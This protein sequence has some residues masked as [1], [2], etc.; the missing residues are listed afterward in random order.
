MDV[1]RYLFIDLFWGNFC[2]KNSFSHG[3]FFSLLPFIEYLYILDIK[4]L[5]YKIL[6]FRYLSCI[7]GADVFVLIINTALFGIVRSVYC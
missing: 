6:K 7:F 5:S 2:V 4:G 1:L 3:H